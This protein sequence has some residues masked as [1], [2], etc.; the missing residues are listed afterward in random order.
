[1]GFICFG[2]PKQWNTGATFPRAKVTLK[3][4]NKT[5]MCKGKVAGYSKKI[6][7]QVFKQLKI[8]SFTFLQNCSNAT[9]DMII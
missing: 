2:E 7:D 6:N 5:Q 3:N 8:L 4:C 1:M 9:G